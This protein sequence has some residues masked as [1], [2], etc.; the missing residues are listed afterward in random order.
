MSIIEAIR[1]YERKVI[2]DVRHPAIVT[3]VMDFSD[4]LNWSLERPRRNQTQCC[5]CYQLAARVMRYL[6]GY[7]NSHRR[8]CFIR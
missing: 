3:L 4:L 2:V 6:L 7:R 5:V 1:S 8:I